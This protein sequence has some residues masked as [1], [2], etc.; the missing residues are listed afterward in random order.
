MSINRTKWKVC[1][2]LGENLWSSPKVKRFNKKKWAKA[3]KQKIGF[4]YPQTSRNKTH[5]QPSLYVYKGRLTAK[6][7]LRNFYGNISEK[8]FKAT[9]IK[10]KLKN[11]FVGLLE[12]R[13]DTV[14]YRMGFVSTVFAA[15]QFISHGSVVVNGLRADVK[16]ASLKTGDFLEITTK[17]WP[18]TFDEL[19][20][21]FKDKEQ[22][23]HP[24]PRHLEVNYSVLKA[25]FLGEPSLTETSYG[26]RMNVDLVKEFYK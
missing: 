10:S 11:N 16:S 18:R 7:K 25:V 13:L 26:S 22:T 17:A 8:T 9:Y 3:K 1:A 19:D 24:L 5:L 23:L 20:E 2:A 15:R 21:R 12:S 4:Y 14:L 6:Q